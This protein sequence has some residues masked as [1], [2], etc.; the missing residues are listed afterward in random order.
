MVVSLIESLLHRDIQQ[1]IRDHTH[2]DSREIAIQQKQLLGVS[3]TILAQ[4]IAARQKAKIKLPLYFQAS[5]IVYPPSLN[6]EQSSSQATAQ[7]KAQILAS[8]F[9]NQSANVVD[10]TGG[11]GIDSFFLSGG[12]ASLLHIEVN[13]ELQQIATHNHLQLG[14]K[15]IAYNNT[16]AESFLE[17]SKARFDFIY[18]DPSRRRESERVYGLA[19]CV[20]NVV[21]LQEKIFEHTTYLLLKTSP[22][23]DIHFVLKSLLIVK[24]VFVVGVENECKEVL[25]LI[26][27]KVSDAL[28]VIEAVDLSIDGTVKN[29]FTFTFQKEAETISTFSEPLHYLYEPNAAILKAGA[30]KSI[31]SYFS[32]YKIDTN[33]HLYTSSSL[34]SDF[35]GRVFKIETTVKSDDKEV[36]KIIPERKA[37]IIT[38]NYPLSADQLKKKLKLNDGGHKYLLAFSAGN[39]KTILLC[40]RIK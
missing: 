32:I 24:K 8:L 22:L 11:F 31:A 20:P 6:L 10:L 35:P 14:A 18:I 2:V 33:T 9:T 23:L 25:Y 17:S 4:Q 19:D 12:C 27:R 15:N 26:D 38:R 30:F 40:S 5:N 34:F 21:A 39:K 37:N 16:S 36:Y 13:T 29:S 1:F 7:F 28:P 3:Y